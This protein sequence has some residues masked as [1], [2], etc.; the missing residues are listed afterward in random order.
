MTNALSHL[1]QLTNQVWLSRGAADAAA[2]EQ[3]PILLQVL[4]SPTHRYASLLLLGRYV[5][6]GPFAVR[7]TLLTQP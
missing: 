2:P 4:L 3:L 6:L 7:E 1:P 5:S